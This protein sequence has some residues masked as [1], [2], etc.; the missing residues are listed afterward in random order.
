MVWQAGPVQVIVG[1]VSLAVRFIWSLCYMSSSHT[2]Q[3]S[4][5]LLE[6]SQKYQLSSQPCCSY[7]GIP[8]LSPM[9]SSLKS[10]TQLWLIA[11]DI[12][13]VNF[14]RT[15]YCF[16]PHCINLGRPS[17]FCPHCCSLE[18]PTE[19]RTMQGPTRAGKGANHY[20][21]AIHILKYSIF[22][23]AEKI[24]PVVMKVYKFPL[25][26]KSRDYKLHD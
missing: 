14:P 7:T 11:F 16:T 10:D 22:N 25:H 19:N 6:A 2:H 4:S 20:R 18:C 17:P 1:G 3:L 8:Q 9:L 12:I 13:I 21:C 24:V 5:W 23:R 15:L 26:L